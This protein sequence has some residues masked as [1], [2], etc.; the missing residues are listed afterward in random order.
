MLDTDAAGA[1]AVADRL[2]LRTPERERLIAVA[3]PCDP[4]LRATPPAAAGT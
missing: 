4:P 3:A 2:R 1:S